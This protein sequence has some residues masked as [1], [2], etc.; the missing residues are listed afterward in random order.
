MPAESAAPFVGRS[1]EVERLF[2]LA[3]AGSGGRPAAALISAE[4]A[5][6][7]ARLGSSPMICTAFVS[8]HRRIRA[9]RLGR[10]RAMLGT[11]SVSV[12]RDEQTAVVAVEGWAFDAARSADE[13]TLALTADR[14]AIRVLRTVLA[15]EIHRYPD[16]TASPSRKGVRP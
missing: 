1:D 7:K 16:R 3:R 8:Y 14:G 5:L 13:A 10:R 12:L 2:E 6:G 11:T 4:P 15:S 9:T